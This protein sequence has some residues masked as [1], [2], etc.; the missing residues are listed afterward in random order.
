MVSVS[1]WP[2]AP[3][4]RPKAI[5]PS[6]MGDLEQ[7][8]QD[9]ISSV[10]LQL[11]WSA[12]PSSIHNHEGKETKTHST[13]DRLRLSPKLC[14]WSTC[15]LRGPARCSLRFFSLHF[16]IICL[17]H[18]LDWKCSMTSPQQDISRFQMTHWDVRWSHLGLR[19]TK[20]LVRQGLPKPFTRLNVDGFIKHSLDLDCQ[21]DQKLIWH[22][23]W[24]LKTFSSSDTAHDA[25]F[26]G[27]QPSRSRDPETLRESF[28]LLFM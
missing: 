11:F 23:R 17:V 24:L 5:S 19:H 27:K 10:F 9:I 2:E 28:S 25:C 13:E 18:E 22:I 20:I 4:G 21:F 6:P 7:Q 15:W 12:S 3:G 16:H 14:T 1:G 8:I 26:L